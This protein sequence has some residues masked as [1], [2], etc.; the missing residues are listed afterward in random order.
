MPTFNSFKDLAK[1]DQDKAK[2]GNAVTNVDPK[3]IAAIAKKNK[4]D[5]AKR[6]EEFNKKK[7]ESS[8]KNQCVCIDRPGLI[9][10]LDYLKWINKEEKV[11]INIITKKRMRLIEPGL[12]EE[13]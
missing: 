5:A 1:Y 12:F 10:K 13:L 2:K 7:I 6:Q 4:Q 11:F 8:L 9:G 3:K